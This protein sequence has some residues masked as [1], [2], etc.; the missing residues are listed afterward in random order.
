[1]NASYLESVIAQFEYYKLLGEKTFAQLR[2]EQLLWQH[3]PESN[4]VASIVKHLWGNMLSRWTNFLTE[5][6]EKLWREREAEFDNDI[7]SRA[8][9]LTKWNE[10]WAVLLDT[11]RALKPEDLDKIVYI[12]NQGH[13]VVEAINRQLAHYPYHVGQIVYIGKMAAEAWTSLSIPRGATDQFNK[14]K[15]SQPPHREHFTNEFLQKTAGDDAQDLEKDAATLFAE[16]W[17]RAF[18]AHDIDDIL[19]HYSDDIEFYSPLIKK[20]EFNKEGMIRGKPELKRYFERGLAAYPGLNFIVH[21]I[22][23]GV[24]TVTVYY[25][26]VNGMLA[27]ETFWLDA[28]GKAKRVICQYSAEPSRY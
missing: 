3:N 6:G 26:S 4:S 16:A 8:E 23:T 11:L 5:D 13:T 15:F 14:E 18:N 20:L 22:F 7:A 21:N 10:G 24:D 27:A 1:M 9:M 25:T 2:D 17:V 28:G 12:R 19:G